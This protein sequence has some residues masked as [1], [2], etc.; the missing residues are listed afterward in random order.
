MLSDF[1]KFVLLIHVLGIDKVFRGDCT[2][3]KVYEEGTK[4]IALSVV[5]GINCKY[6]TAVLSFCLN[7]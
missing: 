7:K 6:N 2:T 3:R 5:N 4:E 1:L